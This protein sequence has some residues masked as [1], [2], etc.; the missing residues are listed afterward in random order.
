MG[1]RAR[2]ARN[3]C[4]SRTSSCQGGWCADQGFLWSLGDLFAATEARRGRKHGLRCARGR[5]GHLRALPSGNERMSKRG[6]RLHSP[7]WIPDQAFRDKVHEQFIITA[8]NSG[9]GFRTRTPS[10]TLRIDHRPWS[11][12]CVCTAV[13]IPCREKKT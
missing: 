8:K 9:K 2:C 4:S 6:L 13:R 3:S 12:S 1:G 5:T 11:P 7:L 10:S